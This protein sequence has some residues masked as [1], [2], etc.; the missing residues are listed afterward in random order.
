MFLLLYKFVLIL[1]HSSHSLTAVDCNNSKMPLGEDGNDWKKKTA[2]IK[3]IYDF[4]D[5]LGT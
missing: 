3:D 4:K 1:L 5:V 2:D